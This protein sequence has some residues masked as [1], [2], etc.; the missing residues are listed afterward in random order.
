LKNSKPEKNPT[1]DPAFGTGS[2]RQSV[3]SFPTLWKMAIKMACFCCYKQVQHE[4]EGELNNSTGSLRTLSG[5][6]LNNFF[7]DLVS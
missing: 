2:G 4:R 1:A 5:N 7:N 3:V 6:S